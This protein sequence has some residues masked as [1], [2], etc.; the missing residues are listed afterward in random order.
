MMVVRLLAFCL[1]LFALAQYDE[2]V[3]EVPA[4]LLVAQVHVCLSFLPFPIKRSVDLVVTRRG[5]VVIRVEAA[6]ITWIRIRSP[7][8]PTRPVKAGINHRPTSRDRRPEHRRIT[9]RAQS[10]A[11]NGMTFT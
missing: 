8:P 2:V 5:P 7:A 10:S 6:P 9:P 3:V 4:V 1:F 11:P